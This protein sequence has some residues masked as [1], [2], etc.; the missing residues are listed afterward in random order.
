M[1]L[2]D[3]DFDSLV[4]AKT[5]T[6]ELAFNL[7][8]MT[9]DEYVA[10]VT[11][12]INKIDLT[13]IPI[14]KWDMLVTFMLAALEVGGDFFIGDPDFKNSLANK[15][16]PFCKWLDKFHDKA[17]STSAWWG[18]KGSVLDY[19]GPEIA[20][21]KGAH[22]GMTFAHD[23]P[24]ARYLYGAEINEDDST[25]KKVAKHTYN[26]ALIAHDLLCFS[27]S[28]Y[29]ICTGKFVDC[30]F[31][32]DGAY[33]W[34]VKSTNQNG[35]PYDPCN[36][37]VGV[38]KYLVHM[39]ADFCSSSSLPIPGWSLLTHFPDRDVEAFA[40]KL[41]RNGMN[42]RTMALQS[43]PVG[44]TEL[45]MAVYI[46]VRSKNSEELYSDEAWDHKKNKLL[47]IAHGITSAVN[48][49]KVIIT[50][51]PWRLNLVVIARTFQ[52]IWKVLEEETKLT[53]NHILKL[54][55]QILRERIESSKTL[56]LLDEILYETDNLNLLVDEFSRRGDGLIRNTEVR[57]AE[58]KKEVS[59]LD[60]ILED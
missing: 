35:T 17:S 56:V 26:G 58:L 5:F 9:A 15:N 59:K 57:S 18:H 29:S 11:D 39:L 45:L 49:G 50:K 8:G 7:N 1:T 13:C 21:S 4:N 6:S 51:S 31:T 48:I 24:L 44:V 60:S 38:V 40:L 55:S 46:W 10:Q 53:N 20:G 14:D 19:Q 25:A 28:L 37:F 54:D 2:N 3:I 43:V 12:E 47:L 32:K 27:L 52:L 42:L 34:I 23:L 33:E 30:A 41:Y 16:G 36:V 22:R